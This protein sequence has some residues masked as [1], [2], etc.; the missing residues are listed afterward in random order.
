MPLK[1]CQCT[2]RLLRSRKN[3]SSPRL[4]KNRT[5]APQTTTLE[6][7]WQMCAHQLAADSRPCKC[8]QSQSHRSS[9]TRLRQLLTA[10]KSPMR[11]PSMVRQIRWKTRSV[12]YACASSD[13]NPSS[14]KSTRTVTLSQ[15]GLTAWTN[16]TRRLPAT[17]SSMVSASK[18]GWPGRNAARAAELQFESLS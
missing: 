14:R 2:Y 6:A 5:Q 8:L 4:N 7:W 16:S 9:S 10:M 15:L 1:N 12:P 18:R 17:M 3:Q 11:W 13:T